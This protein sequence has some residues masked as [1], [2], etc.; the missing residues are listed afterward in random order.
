MRKN[1]LLIG[2]GLVVAVL[3]VAAV[4]CDDDDDDDGGG[5]D[6]VTQITITLSEAAGSGITG[7]ATLTAM[8]SDVEVV[9]EATGLDEANTYLSGAYDSTSVDCMGG[10]LG[11]F[12][13]SFTG[14]VGGVTY[15]VTATTVSDIVSVSVRDTTQSGSPPGT[16]VACG[17]VE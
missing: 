9:V 10:R 8:D 12:S 5:G 17:L 16:V 4:A 11:D 14:D 1:W 13:S 6:G 7:T 3:A 15:T 2:I